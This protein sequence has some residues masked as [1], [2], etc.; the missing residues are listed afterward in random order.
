MPLT[1][2][3]II[4][5]SG[6]SILYSQS[7]P[8]YGQNQHHTCHIDIAGPVTK[9][10]EYWRFE[11][12][13]GREA[14]NPVT[15]S[16]GNIYVGFSFAEDKTEA[17]YCSLDSLG[18]VRWEKRLKLSGGNY[19]ICDTALDEERNHVYFTFGNYFEGI[20]AYN[21]NGDFIWKCDT[22]SC[23]YPVTISD[24]GNIYSGSWGISLKCISPEGVKKWEFLDENSSFNNFTGP[25]SLDN[26]GHV[27]LPMGDYVYCLNADNGQQVWRVPIHGVT[28]KGVTIANNSIYYV[29]N[30]N[31]ICLDMDGNEKWRYDGVGLNQE[32]AICAI[33]TNGDIIVPGYRGL[34]CLQQDG[35]FKFKIPIMDFHTIITDY[36]NNIFVLDEAHPYDLVCYNSVGTV[37]W[38][39]EREYSYIQE[40]CFNKNG[41]IIVADCSSLICYSTKTGFSSSNST[42]YLPGKHFSV[43]PNPFTSRLSISLPSSGAIYSLTGQLI[44]NLPKGKHSLDTSKWREGVYI[45]KSGKECKRIVKVR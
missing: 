17:Y 37:V 12:K 23:Q 29:D 16:N 31:F 8:M 35:S 21:L 4:L 24:N 41:D 44:K 33:Q 7:Y 22:M 14:G 6:I 43:S 39:I 30:G 1:K 18:K 2:I 32:Q 20:H 26:T 42:S 13:E 9:P 19:S 27:Y 25:P 28:S 15:D 10:N 11:E 34:S 3:L 45:V 36:N 5:I 38:N 40:M